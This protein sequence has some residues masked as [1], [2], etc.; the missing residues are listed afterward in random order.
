[1]SITRSTSW[2]SA[3]RGRQNLILILP[4]L[5]LLAARV[6]TTTVH[7]GSYLSVAAGTVAIFAGLVIR[8]LARQWKAERCTGGL[9]TDGL[10]AWVRNPLYLGSF[11]LG[12]GL[13]LVVGDPL[14]LGAFLL[15]FWWSHGAVIRAEEEGLTARYGEV[16][17]DYRRRVP[18]LFP[19]RFSGGRLLPAHLGQALLRECDS[20][21]AWL[22]LPLVIHLGRWCAHHRL[23]RPP[24]DGEV[25][26]LASVLVPVVVLGTVWARMKAASRALIRA[27]RACRAPA[28][29][30]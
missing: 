8:V 12:A 14:L 3:S 25:F 6:V 9:V 26:L 4:L 16:Y 21:F 7:P 18:A 17:R 5:A 1:M 29:P 23:H 15:F 27:E 22:A 13:C 19:A 24:T 2:R 20:L 28:S 11:M 10:Y 30:E